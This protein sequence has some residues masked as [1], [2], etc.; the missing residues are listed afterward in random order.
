MGPSSAPRAAPLALLVAGSCCL[1]AHV[2]ALNDWSGLSADL[3]DPN[4]TA[5]VFAARGIDPAEIGWLAM[6]LLAASVLLFARLGART[7]E[8]ALAV[9]VLSALYSGPAYHAKGIP[10]LSSA[11][12]FAGGVFH[13]LLG[14][15]LFRPVDRR[16]CEIACFFALSFVAGHLTQEVRDH[17]GDRRNGI[18]T[19]AVVFGMRRSFGAAVAAFTLAYGLL[20][21]LA[22]GG[23]VPRPLAAL[24][25]LYPLQLYWSLRTLGDGLTFES[26]RRLQA[27]YRGLYAVIGMA[28]LAALLLDR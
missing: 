13:F 4:K 19:N 2:F 8:M 21:A 23:V 7:V 10:L 20:A 17:D 26:V 12:H 3:N 9:A 14:Y 24:A 11:V 5:N 22:A 6:A 28:M 27:R 18:R 15:S 25:A 16:G 1:V